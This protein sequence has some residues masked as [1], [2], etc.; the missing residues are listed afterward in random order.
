M[1][2]A[3]GLLAIA[4]AGCGTPAPDLFEVTRSGR[5]ANANVR[6]L[7]NDSGTVKC[8]DMAPKALDGPRLLAARDIARGIA[9]QA[10][11]AISLEPGQNPTL[12]YEV[13]T[14]SGTVEFSDR[15]EGRPKAYDRLVAFTADVTE[16]VCGLER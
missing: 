12:R 6:L 1:R 9:R 11:L 16:N 3:L 13:R 8:N 5:D 14:E 15:S 10:E 2:G 4:F 7:V